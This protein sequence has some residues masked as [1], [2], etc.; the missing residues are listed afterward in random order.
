MA[1]AQFLEFFQ[2]WGDDPLVIQDKIGSLK[3]LGF[4]ME[5]LALPL[6]PDLG[7][8]LAQRLGNE[9]NSLLA[10]LGD[11]LFDRWSRDHKLSEVVFQ[12]LRDWGLHSPSVGV[13]VHYLTNKINQGKGDFLP[14]LRRSLWEGAPTEELRDKFRLVAASAK[15]RYALNFRGKEWNATSVAAFRRSFTKETENQPDGEWQLQQGRFHLRIGDLPT[16]FSLLKKSLL[17]AQETDNKPLEVRAE[18]EI[19][20]ALLRKGRIDEGHE[21]FDIASRLADKTGSSYLIALT[22]GLDAVSLFLLGNL[23]GVR[24]ALDRGWAACEKGGLQH[25]K[26]Q[27]SFLRARTEF[28]LGNYDGAS[29]ALERALAVVDRYRLL[30]AEPVLL[31]WKGRSEAYAGRTSV[32]QSLLEALPPS[33]ERGYFLAE[34]HYF[35][36]EYDQARALIREARELLKPTQPFGS[37]EKADWSTGFAGV[38]DRALGQPGALGVLGNQ[39]EAFGWLVEGSLGEEA[40]TPFQNL[41]GRKFLLEL[42]PASAMIYYWYYRVLPQDDAQ[43]AQRLTLLGRCLKDVQTRASR[44]EDPT[45]RQDYVSRPLWNA[46][47][48][49]DARKLK[50]L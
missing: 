15:L 13:L 21:Y 42:D 4:L 50:L 40:A 28:D 35:Q 8:R 29:E 33:A 41:L 32:A 1:E 9:G 30:E 37:G 31:S 18:S 46:R 20:L 14:L 47:F 45:Q 7:T 44:I 22:A 27:F 16:G 26:V 36:H 48:A 3:S 38:E 11:F 19:G 12:V 24:G 39:I 43:M 25:G 17:E 5:G 23:T 34:T 49:Q 6:R 2:Q 10:S